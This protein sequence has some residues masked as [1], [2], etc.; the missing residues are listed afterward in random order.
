MQIE[1]VNLYK[2]RDGVLDI[3]LV[4]KLCHSHPI[5]VDGFSVLS[6]QTSWFV[7]D[8]CFHSTSHLSGNPPLLTTSVAV[9]GRTRTPSSL[10]WVVVGTSCWL[11]CLHLASFKSPVNLADRVCHCKSVGAPYVALSHL[12]RALR[13]EFLCWPMR[14]CQTQPYFLPDL[15]SS[16][17]WYQMRK[18][19]SVTILILI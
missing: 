10:I 15:M 3:P 8:I 2:A 4:P 6:G 7:L 1:W 16:T 19:C 14:P 5:L 9:L 13:C 18:Q 11:L 12:L 17:A